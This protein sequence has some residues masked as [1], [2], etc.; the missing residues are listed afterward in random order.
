MADIGLPGL[1]DFVVRM[2]LGL[3]E[4]DEAGPR[5]PQEHEQCGRKGEGEHS[6]DEQHYESH[7]APPFRVPTRVTPA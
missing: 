4:A 5:L 1:D 3:E 2:T 6:N 7:R